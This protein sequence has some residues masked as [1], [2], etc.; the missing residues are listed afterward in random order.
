MTDLP[1]PNEPKFLPTCTDADVEDAIPEHVVC[2]YC[3]QAYWRFDREDDG[4]TVCP[5]CKAL[6]ESV[7]YRRAKWCADNATDPVIARWLTRHPPPRE[8][9]GS[10]MEWAWHARPIPLRELATVA[11]EIFGPGVVITVSPDGTTIID[12]QGNRHPVRR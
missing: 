4:M 12:E 10:G 2:P 7:E 11:E 6:W 8:W 5:H 9:R 1:D 3:N